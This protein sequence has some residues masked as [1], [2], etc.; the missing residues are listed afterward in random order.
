MAEL[1]QAQMQLQIIDQISDCDEDF[2]FDFDEDSS[3]EV[4]YIAQGDIQYIG[5][6]A[7]IISEPKVPALEQNIILELP[8]QKTLSVQIGEE[9][10][11]TGNE[12]E[13][14]N[15]TLGENSTDNIPEV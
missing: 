12:S 15:S 6:C 5:D 2:D 4:S 3:D 7:P 8:T 9:P 14:T 13:A 1:K 10:E 11:S